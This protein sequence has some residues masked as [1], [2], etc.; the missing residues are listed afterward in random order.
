MTNSS[1]FFDDIKIPFSNKQTGRIINSNFFFIPNF[2][3]SGFSFADIEDS[4]ESKRREETIFILLYHFHPLTNI[5]KFTCNFAREM[6]T[7]YF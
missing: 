2:F 7:A 5:Q 4:Q 3:K 1:N 6:T